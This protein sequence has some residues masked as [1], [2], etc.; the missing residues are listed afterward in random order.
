MCVGAAQADKAQAA[1]GQ[2]GEQGRLDLS[3]LPEE[4]QHVRG[5]QPCGQGLIRGGVVGP[6]LWRGE[7]VQGSGPMEGMGFR[8]P[9]L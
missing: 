8:V 7:G 6:H 5:L 2:E 1:R 3:A 4:H 9:D